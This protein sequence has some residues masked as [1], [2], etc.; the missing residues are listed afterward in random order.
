MNVLNR[1][2]FLEKARTKIRLVNLGEEY[3]AVHVR[4]LTLRQLKLVQSL[5]ENDDKTR[6]MIELVALIVVDEAGSPMLG[7]ADVAELAESGDMKFLSRVVEEIMK[8]AG[9]SDS[10]IEAAAKN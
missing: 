7:E 10:K 5:N 2:T 8:L 4:P 6:A 3:G 1:D 9:L